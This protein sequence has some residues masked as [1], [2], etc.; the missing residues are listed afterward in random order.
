MIFPKIID[1]IEDNMEV[2]DSTENDLNGKKMKWHANRKKKLII[3]EVITAENYYTQGKFSA[4]LKRAN[5]LDNKA[6][7]LPGNLVILPY[8]MKLIKLFSKHIETA[9]EQYGLQEH[10]YPLTAPIDSFEAE[11][12]IF[13]LK[14][15]ILYIA[16]DSELES[17]SPRGVLCP[18]GEATIYTH[19]SKEIT[20]SSDLPITLYQKTNYFRPFSSGKHTGKGIFRALEAGDIFEFHSCFATKEQALFN[21]R[22][23]YNMLCEI[24]NKLHVPTLWTLRPPWTNNENL[25]EWSMGGDVPLP[26]GNTVQTATLYNQGDVFSKAYNITF[27]T[28]NKSHYTQQVT[29]C[30]T[31]RLILAHLMLGMDVEGNLFVHPDLSPTQVS[32]IFKK[33]NNVHNSSISNFIHS[34]AVKYR[35]SSVISNDK[36]VIIKHKNQNLCQGVP[37]EIFIQDK[38]DS[39]DKYKIVFTRCDTF[40]K[41]EVYVDSLDGIIHI[42]PSIMQMIGITFKQKVDKFYKNQLLQVTTIEQLSS[43]KNKLKLFPLL[44][45]KKCCLDI[46]KMCNGEILGFLETEDT[47]KCI[48]TGKK[49]KYTAVLSRRI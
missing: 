32:I 1:S 9:F 40:E 20:T 42:I 36:K 38:R 24:S 49:T 5:I 11:K 28:D 26:T 47:G 48:L 46:E 7:D 18:T 3:D 25:Y 35:V 15:K 34:V 33:N 13:N 39:T 37:L 4:A 8:G 22:K 10:S 14:D 27:K 16:N 2:Q 29:G 19:W 44:F 21:L 17:G 6:V 43:A 41:S 12:K 45:D 23:Y 30:V 31:R